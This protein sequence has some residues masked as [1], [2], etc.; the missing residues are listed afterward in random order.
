[1]IV[2]ADSSWGYFTLFSDVFKQHGLP[3]SI[4]SD[5]H[6][7]FRTNREPTREQ[8]INKRPTSEV[9]CDR[10]RPIIAR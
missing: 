5:Y 3:Q 9:G 2:Q 7:V 6:T 10:K 8:L 1:V 4:Y